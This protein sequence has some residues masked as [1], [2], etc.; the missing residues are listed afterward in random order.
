M[1]EQSQ[2]LTSAMDQLIS[3]EVTSTWDWVWW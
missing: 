3:R 1:K 2:T